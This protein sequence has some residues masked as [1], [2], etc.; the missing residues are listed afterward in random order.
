[1]PPVAGAT[2]PVVAVVRS[3]TRSRSPCG[4]TLTRGRVVVHFDEH[5]RLTLDEGQVTVGLALCLL[6][7][8][9]VD[10]EVEFRLATLKD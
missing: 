1:M 9:D 6:I 2:R 5:G 4:S 3:C 8:E 7:V 10:L